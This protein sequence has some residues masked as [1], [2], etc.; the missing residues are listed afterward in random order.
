MK[1]ALRV[2]S[3][4]GAAICAFPELALTGYHRRIVEWAT[5]EAATPAIE[6][7]RSASASIGIA[8]TF[9]SPTFGAY[10]QRFNSQLFVDAS[11]TIAGT[12]SK[13][14]LTEAEAAFFTRGQDR[15]SVLLDGLRCTAVMCREIEDHTD[16]L[17]SLA[18]T[19]PEVVFWPGL[20]SPDPALPP[21][22]P[23][24]HVVQAQELARALGAYFVQANWP[25]SLNRPEDSKGTGRSACISPAGDLLFRLP[26]QEGGVAVFNLGDRVFSWQASG[27]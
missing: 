9:G 20:M 16:V 8:A 2:A 26:E 6:E 4:H 13:V 19:R 24:R 11:G 7:V 21:Q 25:N 3:D 23:P 17:A 15:P 12:V 14:G 1:R 5:P 10:G 27:A 22:D 18:S